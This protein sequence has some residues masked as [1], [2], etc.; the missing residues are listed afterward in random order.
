VKFRE[1]DIAG[2]FLL[3]PVPIEDAR[4]FFAR[5]WCAR[6]LEERGLNGQVAQMSM[7]YNAMRGTLRGMHWQAAPFEEAK[8]VRCTNGSVFDV[9]ADIR[10]ESPTFM[11]WSAFR[12]SRERRAMLYIPGGVAHGFQTLEDE[13]EL[14][15]QMSVEYRP[16]AARGFAWNDP[17]F[18]IPWPIANPILSP[19][20]RNY[21]RFACF[22]F[23]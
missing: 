13:T 12:L 16:E 22:A 19:K 1:T 15:Y 14:A 7:S 3:E 8:I 23:A 6:E 11:R 21:E 2:A 10:P 5:T 17:A 9:I 4:G 20:D 18:A